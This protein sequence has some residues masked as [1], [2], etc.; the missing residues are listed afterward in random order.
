M[1]LGTERIKN[2]QANNRPVLRAQERSE[3]KSGLPREFGGDWLRILSSLKPS[4][5]DRASSVGVVPSS[6]N[7]K[8]RS[9]ESSGEYFKVLKLYMKTFYLL[10][11]YIKPFKMSSFYKWIHENRL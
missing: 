9:S 8:P 4:T 1:E 7:K 11:L 5:T 6:S 3:S 2:N 10:T